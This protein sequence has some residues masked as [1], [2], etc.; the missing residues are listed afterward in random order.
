MKTDP[1]ILRQ[2]PACRIPALQPVLTACC[3]LLVKSTE[4]LQSFQMMP[5]AYCILAND[6]LPTDSQPPNLS[7][8][9]KQAAMLSRMPIVSKM[10]ADPD[11]ISSLTAQSSQ[12]AQV[13]DTNPCMRDMLQSQAVSQELQA[14]QDPRCLQDLLGKQILSSKLCL[15]LMTSLFAAVALKTGYIGLS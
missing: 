12:L 13:M 10:L 7:D 9:Q 15:R 14:A 2:A 3:V 11:F 4:G 8:L 6:M 1:E 5:S